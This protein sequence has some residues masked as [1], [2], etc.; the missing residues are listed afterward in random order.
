[1]AGALESRQVGVVVAVVG[2]VVRDD[3]LL[4]GVEA[5][6]VPRTL[7]L[8]NL[9]RLGEYDVPEALEILT[10]L[11]VPQEVLADLGGQNGEE[12]GFELLV[13]ERRASCE[14]VLSHDVLELRYALLYALEVLNRLKVYGADLA[15]ERFEPDAASV[16]DVTDHTAP[17][18]QAIQDLRP[19]EQ[20]FGGS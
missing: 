1:M 16:V 15:S 9:L 4:G 6:E 20:R 3:V 11:L 2:V 17:S 7:V 19:L 10:V 13:L 14:G 5:V 8:E 12:V 18:I